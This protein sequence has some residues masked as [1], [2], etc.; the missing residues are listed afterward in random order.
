MG[1][2]PERLNVQIGVAWF[3]PFYNRTFDKLSQI[4]LGATF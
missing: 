3:K 4:G 1:E 2:V